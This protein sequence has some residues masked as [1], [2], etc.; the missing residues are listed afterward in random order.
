MSITT[1]IGPMFSGKTTELT[2]LMRRKSIA[3]FNCAI[4]KHNNDTRYSDTYVTS[5]DGIE[6]RG[7]DVLH[8]NTLVIY[9]YLRYDVIGIDEG[10]MFEGLSEFCN[11]MATAWKKELIIASIDT[12]YRQEMFPEI[13]RLIGHTDNVV[14]LTAICMTC[15]C[16][17]AI[18]TIRLTDECDDIVVGGNER[19]AC[20][21]RRCLD[22]KKW[23]AIADNTE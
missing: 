17:N 9:D 3:G 14:K 12:S 7:C 21:C 15:K 11:T 18:Y 10:F 13:S 4:I 5:H 1:I 22:N 8:V 20:I 2:R 6:Y 23:D 19:Y 16:D